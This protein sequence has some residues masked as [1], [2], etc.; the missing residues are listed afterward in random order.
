PLLINLE[1]RT[2][3][4]GGAG[5]ELVRQLPHAVCRDF[6]SAVG[7]AREWRTPHGRLN[8][9]GAVAFVASHLKRIV[10][11][12]HAVVLG[13]PPYLT[14]PQIAQI[15]EGLVRA[16][17]SVVGSAS[18]PLALAATCDA[19]F[20]TALVLDA[21]EHALTWSVLAADGPN[22]RLLA[23]HAVPSASVRAWQ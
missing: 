3:T 21:D 15:T 1:N 12:G 6:L 23:H 13:V 8:A 4:L 10:P 17:I 19:G 20:G 11:A 14:N 18:A 16:G 7:K 2:P 5:Y 9:E 22:A